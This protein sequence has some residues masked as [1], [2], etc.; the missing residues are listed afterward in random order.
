MQPH[1]LPQI[2]PEAIEP[3]KKF[4]YED[5]TRLIK[6]ERYEQM[7]RHGY[8][9][10]SDQKYT[11]EELPALATYLLTGDLN[12]WPVEM[13]DISYIEKWKVKTR[14]EQLAIAGALIAA[15]IDRINNAQVIPGP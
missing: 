5:G 13:L 2:N 12:F 4:Y 1:D 8:T 3:K 7:T 10:E 11:N 14:V 9:L 6:V 15:E